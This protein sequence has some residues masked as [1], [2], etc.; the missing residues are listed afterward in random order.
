MSRWKCDVGFSIDRFIHLFAILKQSARAGKPHGRSEELQARR[1]KAPTTFSAWGNSANRIVNK[2]MFVFLTPT[3]Y[4]GLFPSWRLIANSAESG[5]NGVFWQSPQFAV[6]IFSI[7]GDHMQMFSFC[8]HKYRHYLQIRFDQEKKVITS[9]SKH[10][11][12]S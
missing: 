3:V 2:W 5:Y 4:P 6:A 11:I 8:Q 7:T 9:K 1:K 10:A 12:L